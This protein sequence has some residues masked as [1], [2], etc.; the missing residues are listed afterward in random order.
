MQPPAVWIL[1]FKKAGRCGAAFEPRRGGSEQQ[2][3]SEGE[4]S[5]FLIIFDKK[6]KG[7]CNKKLPKM[8][9]AFIHRFALQ[10]FLNFLFLFYCEQV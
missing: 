2:S 9:A 7:A 1:N 6:I 4:T 10:I 8:T 3:A 5:P